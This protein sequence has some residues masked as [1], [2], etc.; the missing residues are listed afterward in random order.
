MKVTSSPKLLYHCFSVVSLN[1]SHPSHLL[2]DSKY[3]CVAGSCRF[4]GA[5]STQG[6]ACQ[7]SSPCLYQLLGGPV[8]RVAGAVRQLHSSATPLYIY[9]YIYMLDSSTREIN[10]KTSTCQCSDSIIHP[11]SIS[12]KY[13]A[14]ATRPCSCFLK[15]FP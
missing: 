11:L 5:V 6:P 10:A 14:T 4:L 13:S 7:K 12:K 8:R 2:P 9:I 3:T 1:C 15:H